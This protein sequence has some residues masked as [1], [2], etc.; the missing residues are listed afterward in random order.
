VVADAGG[1]AHLVTTRTLSASERD[2]DG[3][4]AEVGVTTDGAFVG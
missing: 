1:H 3:L 2:R 4:F